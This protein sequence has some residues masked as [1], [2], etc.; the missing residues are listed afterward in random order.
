MSSSQTPQSRPGEDQGESSE[1]I[2]ALLESARRYLGMDLAFLGEFVGDAEVFRMVAGDG[3]SFG[4]GEGTGLPR[5]GTYCQAMIEGRIDQVV[6]DSATAPAVAGLEITATAQIGRYVGVPIHLPDGHL[7]GALCGLG[8]SPDPSL[9]PRDARLLEFLAELVEDELGREEEA[10]RR[11]RRLVDRVSPL[12]DGTGLTM[13]FQ[14]IVDL[15]GAAVAGFEALARF[16]PE[17]VRTPDLWFADAAEAGLGVEL[18]LTAITAALGALGR[19]PGAAYLSINASA[20][21]ACSA[22]LAARLAQVDLSRVVLEIT[23]HAAV[24][25]YEALS[26]ALRPLRAAGLRLAVDDA[27]AGVASLHHI[28]ELAPELIKM[29]ISLTRGI[30][31]SPARA[32]LATALVSFGRATQAAI[33]AEGIETPAEFDALGRLGVSYGQGYLLGRPG[34]LPA[35]LP[36]HST[37]RPRRARVGAAAG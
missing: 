26:A 13:V 33:L 8:H 17:P 31:T 12:L 14:P 37:V 11:H 32:A 10:S 15:S 28:L 36:A 3:T 24:A 30:D 18:E 35:A 21:T 25:N 22:A 27:G 20:E 9:G 5:A 29:D 4:L 34:P 19:V 2:R 1:R 23:E 16:S 6:P 7:Y